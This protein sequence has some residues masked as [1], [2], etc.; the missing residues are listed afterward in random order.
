MDTRWARRAIGRA[1]LALILL[2]PSSCAQLDGFIGGKATTVSVFTRGYESI[3]ARYIDPVDVHKLSIVGLTRLADMDTD[4]AVQDDRGVVRL[5]VQEASA[6]QWLAP[7]P[8]NASG[9]AE[10]TASF[11][12][13][14]RANSA[15]IRARSNEDVYTAIFGG[16]TSELDRYSR[17]ASAESTRRRRATREGF[18]GLGISIDYEGGVTSIVKVHPNTPAERAGLRA[19]DVIT[20][21][22]GKPI[23]ALKQPKVIDILRGPIDSTVVLTLTRPK[24]AKPVEVTV[25]RGLIVIPTVT[26]KSD[27]GYLILKI[28]SFNQGTS[29]AIRRHLSSAMKDRDSPP[30]GIILDLRGNPGGLLDQSVHVADHF[31]NDGLIISSRGRH[32]RSDQVFD[33][34]WGD[35]ALGKR[36][37]VLVNGKSASAAEI[38]AAALHDRGRA[39]VLGSSSYGK[40]SVQT[41]VRMP[42]GGELTLTWARLFTPAGNLLHGRGVTPALCTNGGNESVEALRRA[43]RSDDR[44][45]LRKIMFRL[46]AGGGEPN[47]FRAM[48]AACPPN[49]TQPDTDV[50]LARILMDNGLLYR[51][52][53][54]YGRPSVAAK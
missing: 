23:G 48:R 20:H 11:V 27:G 5:L 1:V 41:I 50:E 19:N 37:V 38:V 51:S 52:V 21:V 32:Y 22:D 17:Y 6:A 3:A 43:L 25:T 29:T 47:G 16:V 31:L 15:I 28:S 49:K 14:T 26:S 30:K 33:A 40:G 54:D 53:L 2:A 4:L 24:V 36:L 34:D 9:W 12:E 35:L 45:R 10:L 7:E 18:G 13:A 8:S 42:N 44:V 46:R 39:V